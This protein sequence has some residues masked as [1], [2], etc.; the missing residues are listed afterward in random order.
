MALVQVLKDLI[1]AFPN[2]FMPGRCHVLVRLQVPMCWALKPASVIMM[3][4][5]C[6]S[7]LMR[8]CNKR[9]DVLLRAK[10]TLQW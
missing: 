6:N 5:G 2:G 8:S 3:P 1:K 7:V 9:N 4:V 10:L